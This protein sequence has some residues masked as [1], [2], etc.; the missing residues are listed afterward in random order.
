MQVLALLGLFAF[1]TCKDTKEKKRLVHVSCHY[2]DHLNVNYV[3]E[4]KRLN[5]SN[6]DNKMISKCTYLNKIYTMCK[7]AYKEAGERITGERSEYILLVLNFLYD[8]CSARTYELGAVTALVLH[9]TSYL[10]VFEGNE[11]SE[12]KAR[13]IFH[14]YG[15]ENYKFLG[16]VSFFYR[17]YYQNPERASHLN[18]YVLVDTAC[19]WLHSSC[20]KKTEIGLN[21][22]LE[23]CNHVQW[24]ILR[25]KWNYSS[26]RVRKAEEEYAIQHEL[27]EK[28]RTI[29]YINYYRDLDVE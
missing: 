8:Y 9:N 16:K 26:S 23:V 5:S 20:H 25:E 19:F 10:R 2:E 17:D 14:V 4:F 29:I 13:G 18:I 24:K 21:D 7:S 3:D 11:Y 6:E 1:A 15:E 27:Y 22:A 12:F 28:L